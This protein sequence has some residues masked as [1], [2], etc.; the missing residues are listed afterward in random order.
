MTCCAPREPSRVSRRCRSAR[1]RS[2]LPTTR[3]EEPARG[4]T[5][6]EISRGEGVA[7]IDADPRA[8]ACLKLA[9]LSDEE[10]HARMKATIAANRLRP[11]HA[12]ADAVLAAMG[13]PVAAAEQEPTG[14]EDAS[15]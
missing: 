6:I 14:G 10:L 15:R 5:D 13:L 2:R 7:A 3:W 12:Q 9:A 1:P 4:R 11:L 8:K